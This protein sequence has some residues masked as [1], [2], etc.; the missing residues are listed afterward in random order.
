MNR[1]CI[2]IGPVVIAGYALAMGVLVGMVTERIRFDHK[3]AVALREH[4]EKTARVR[5]WLMELDVHTARGNTL[6]AASSRRSLRLNSHF[7]PPSATWTAESGLF[8]AAQLR[9]CL[10]ADRVDADAVPIGFPGDAVRTRSL[11]GQPPNSTVPGDPVNE[12]FALG[13][14]VPQACDA[15]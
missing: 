2:R 4:E 7:L 14:L 3:R 11:L 10:T 1:R 12:G 9:R 13:H 6:S 8:S 15:S 5:R